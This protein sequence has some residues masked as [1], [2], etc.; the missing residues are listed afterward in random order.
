MRAIHVSGFRFLYRWDG[1]LISVDGHAKMQQLRTVIATGL[2]MRET[3]DSSDRKHAPLVTY[4]CVARRM[5][6]GLNRLYVSG[7]RSTLT[8]TL[9][10]LIH[11]FS[12]AG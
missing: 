6:V 12:S 9:D 8:L 4:S 3:V 10:K 5:H 7:R 11:T 2:D 1:P